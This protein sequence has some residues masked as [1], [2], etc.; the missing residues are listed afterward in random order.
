MD[1]QKMERAFRASE[2]IVK[3]LKGSLSD[4]EQTEL[5]S[6][7]EESESNR[8]LFS[9]LTN[10]AQ[11]NSL[12]TDYYKANKEAARRKLMRRL[13]PAGLIAFFNNIFFK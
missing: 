9:E 2:L 12:L 7:V 3:Y 1:E 4:A 5:D 8:Q 13:F 6:W 11:L 10:P